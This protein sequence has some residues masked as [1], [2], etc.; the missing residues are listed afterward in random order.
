MEQFQKS[1]SIRLL[2]VPLGILMMYMG[3]KG[4]ADKFARAAMTIAGFMTVTY[5]LNNY[6]KNKGKPGLW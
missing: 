4:G 2:D 3:I 6:L 1:Q 5:N